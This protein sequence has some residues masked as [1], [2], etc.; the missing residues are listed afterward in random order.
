MRDRFDLFRVMMDAIR[1]FGEDIRDGD[2]VVLSSK[3]VALSE[4]R[5]VRLDRVKPSPLAERLAR[6]LYMPKSLVELV[7]READEVYSGIPGFIL[8]LKYGI[9]V[10]NAG[11]DRSNIMPGYAI[12][13]PTRPFIRAEVL[14]GGSSSS[15]VGRLVS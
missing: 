4:G 14:G 10:P 11:V 8:T 9:L 15:L 7:L 3:F 2:I 12:L 5:V 1:G 6:K 13:Y